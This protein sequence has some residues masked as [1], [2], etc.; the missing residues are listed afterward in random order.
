MAETLFTEFVG[1]CFLVGGFEEARTEGRVACEGG[2][3]DPAREGVLCH[4]DSAEIAKFFRAFPG[5]V[6]GCHTEM[7]L[8]KAVSRG[9]QLAAVPLF[10]L[11][12]LIAMMTTFI[13]LEATLLFRLRSLLCLVCLAV[14]EVVAQAQQ[15]NGDQVI[16]IELGEPNIWSLDQ[17]HYLLEQRSLSNQTLQPRRPTADDL[18][19]N[20]VTGNRYR[21]LRELFGVSAGFDQKTGA[22]N[23]AAAERQAS[24][25]ANQPALQVA[26]ANAA[27]RQ[28]DLEQR[29][30]ALRID[31][32]NYAASPA[33]TLNVQANAQLIDLN[34]QLDDAKSEVSKLA[35]KTQDSRPAS[36]TSTAA[37]PALQFV[38]G[39][40]AGV[41]DI[42]KDKLSFDNPKLNVSNAI[43]NFVNFQTEMIMKQVTLLRNEAGYNRRI[44]FVEIPQT[45]TSS[46]Q[47]KPLRSS[48]V[49]E[50]Y[51]VQ[52]RWRLAG[53][54]RAVGTNP[55]DL[56]LLK[57][58]DWVK[59]QQI[60]AK[61]PGTVVPCQ[62]ELT[63]AESAKADK[64]F[65]AKTKQR[66]LQSREKQKAPQGPECPSHAADQC[67]Q[68][69]EEP[70]YPS[71]PNPAPS[72]PAYV[73]P[74]TLRTIELVPR[75]SALN[76]NDRNWVESGIMLKGLFKLL[77]GFGI[78]G[79]YQ[80]QKQAFEQ[81]IT[82]EV[83]G[84]AFGK[85]SN[86]FGWLFGPP[87]GT[88]SLAPGVR[89]TYGIFSIPRNAVAIRVIGCAESYHRRDLPPNGSC[90]SAKV[91][92]F[93][94][95]IPGEWQ[96]GFWLT[97]VSYTP[98]TSGERQVV[99]LRGDYFSTLTGVLVNGVPLRRAV[100]VA[101][102]DLTPPDGKS[103]YTELADG[104]AKGEFEVV[105]QHQMVLAFR[106]PSDFAG[107]PEIT[108]A[109][110]VRARTINDLQLNIGDGSGPTT[111]PA[112]LNS[113]SGKMFK[114]KAAVPVPSVTDL[115]Y[116]RADS[117]LEIMG[118]DLAPDIE[119]LANGE[120]LPCRGVQDRLTCVVTQ[121]HPART[122]GVMRLTLLAAPATRIPTLSRDFPNPFLADLTS[123][124]VIRVQR[125]TKDSP[126]T[127]MAV[128][129]D[130][131]NF[132]D[133]PASYTARF[134]LPGGTW[135]RTATLQFVSPSQLV[136]DIGLPGN[137][138]PAYVVVSVSEGRASVGTL[139]IDLSPPADQPKPEFKTVEIREKK[140]KDPM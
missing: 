136:A 39:L 139:T 128:Q 23:S 16:R 83:Y 32:A 73:A 61:S 126:P 105:N 8:A 49:A 69:L 116:L 66:Q 89:T 92:L 100:S 90:P 17:A 109:T 42:L 9:G 112:T 125:E 64:E 13:C 60:A 26:L 45:I 111:R 21:S 110:P 115:R 40:S 35:A 138:K 30:Q 1:E 65:A 11:R 3:H 70:G 85:G 5:W 36:T 63:P 107:T 38:P 104:G 2:V 7:S 133:N 135:T 114:K 98:K 75:M 76:V 43:D 123:A 56:P 106:M 62:A 53:Y 79:S 6:A 129:I 113:V 74:G 101:H 91:R 84:S 24:D 96:T 88:R 95:P 57:R 137:V 140:V 50:D 71:D 132:N 48:E 4:A 15:R 77:S 108:L 81:Y 27:A 19:P 120:A 47:R 55:E 37:G 12:T 131:R 72:D 118:S 10:C 14:S 33:N 51:R 58:R 117:T 134:S 102:P 86:K 41:T 46:A 25:L 78:E 29:I 52:V 99:F 119:V 31:P 127:A 97:E 18:D 54:L 124:K 44:V 22:D 93:D 130:G 34:K 80:R 20:A 82:Q 103:A 87:P 122:R 94:L 121:G 67:V 28:K 68:Y 59:C